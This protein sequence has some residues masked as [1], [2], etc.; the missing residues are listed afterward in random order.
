MIYRHFKSS[1]KH[2]ISLLFLCFLCS[3]SVYSQDYSSSLNSL[4]PSPV[5]GTL[6][7]IGVM[8][9][10]QPDDNRFT[11]GNGTFET[12]S[13][14]YLENP[15]TS[16]D[17]LPHDR[18][19]F[20]AHLRFSKN[21]FERMSDGQLEIE[22]SVLPE[23]IRLSNKM[24]YYSPI[25]EEPDLSQLSEL[26]R[27]V[28][29]TV[30]ESDMQVPSLQP[31]D[32][33]AFV[34][35]HAG[36]GRDI[37][38]TG[39][40][41]D[42]TPQDIP[43]VY[44]SNEALSEM[45][46]DPSFSGF[47][48]QN[49]NILVTNSLIIPRTLSRSGEDLT[50]ER[51]VLPLSI[52]GMLTA[53]LGSHLGLPDLFNTQTGESGI[54]RFGLMDG[55]G[56]FA[57][58]GLFPPEMSAWEKLHL[59]WTEPTQY[60]T[61]Q[62]TS[63]N[64]PVSSLNRQSSTAQISLSS[65]EYFL[66]E[67]RHRDPDGNG[68]TL[69][70][71]KPDRSIVEQTF[72]HSD[73]DFT[74][75]RSGFDELLEPGV[76]IDVSHY[77]FSLPGGLDEEG[78]R[79]LNGG[80][81]IWHIDDSVIE[82]QL[83]QNLGVNDDPSRKGVQLIEADGAQDIG[84]PVSVGLFQNESNGSAFDFWWSGND[85]TVITQT[86]RITLYE[87]RFGPDTTPQNNSHSGAIS[88]FELFDFSD[89][90]PTAN[91]SIRPVNPFEDLYN[92]SIDRSDLNIETFTPDSDDY[93]NSY[94]LSLS[95]FTRN[96][97]QHIL[98]P[99]NDGLQVYSLN[100]EVLSSPITD[101]QSYQ[102]PLYSIID[103][104]IYLSP[105]PASSVDNIILQ[106][107]EW[108]GETLQLIDEFTVPANRGNLSSVE[109]GYIDLD[110][111]AFR[112]NIDNQTAESVPDQTFFRTDSEAGYSASLS[113]QNFIISYPGGSSEH[114]IFNESS[115]QRLYA[116]LIRVQSGNPLFYLVE[117][118]SLKLFT[119]DN[120]YNQPIQLHD[121][122]SLERPA[123]ADLTNNGAPEFI[124]VN[125]ENHSLIALNQNG[126][127]LDYFP[128]NPPA[129][130]QFSGTPLIADINGDDQMNILI[131]GIDK[132]SLN[133]YAYDTSGELL[134]GFPLL[135]GGIQNLDQRIINPVIFDHYVAA[136]SPAGDLK[137]WEFP[138]MG[139]ISWGSVYGIQN[140]NKSTANISSADTQ[141]PDFTLLNKDETYNWPNPAQ[142]DTNIRFQTSEP[143][144]IEIKI[145]TLS[146]RPIYD[147]KFQ[148]RGGLPEEISID[149]SSWASGGYIALIT[150][151]I[152]EKKESKLIKIAIAR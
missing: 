55:A 83:I 50:G 24:E 105:N 35:F 76:I 132:S 113:G 7:I 139:E 16:V 69:T 61:D 91:F 77:D 10:F 44:L 97:N 51:Y 68:V 53:Q 29:E 60:D 20:E 46:G 106:T 17:A 2:I 39:T 3:P 152:N 9:E 147:R 121:G 40:T 108:D 43:S 36:V 84:R 57:Y 6:H 21:Y 33:I 114:T 119:P 151:E 82:Q 22:Y 19:Y 63:V 31:G 140:D 95:S 94:P 12:G 125:K 127:Y 28:W 4:T 27:E 34:I 122:A 96:G 78:N 120:D 70:I 137:I 48:I 8:A 144:E 99:G 41:L 101:L 136:V 117:D 38:L 102:Q 142:N 85:A 59:G 112:F 107:A 150:A 109:T 67:N 141:I 104:K 103:E 11:S 56:I 92:L 54:G 145:T 15:G 1:G 87:N 71:Q 64:L 118:K 146:G 116:G 5:D 89:N 88:T 100:D 32:N 58:N 129:G 47:P 74:N 111:S 98:I 131:A 42:R 93:W 135:V 138:E 37:E 52:N 126:S 90:L 65:T 133:L 86:D 25:G 75:Q 26:T 49:G 143:A 149:T 14:P 110:G 66:L 62:E 72:S 18:S 79:E 45:M 30:A 115:R 134:D 128:L 124:F 80:I 73:V 13:I 130:V 148:S 123:V 81:L 23:V